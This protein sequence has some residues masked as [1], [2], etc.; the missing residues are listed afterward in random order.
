MW[1]RDRRPRSDPVVSPWIQ[2]LRRTPIFGHFPTIIGP[3]DNSKT[4]P[5]SYLC[6]SLFLACSSPLTMCGDQLFIQRFAADVRRAVFCSC[7][8]NHRFASPESH[9]WNFSNR[10]QT[11]IPQDPTR[12]SGEGCSVLAK[13]IQ[14]RSN[15]WTVPLV[16]QLTN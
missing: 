8:P 10:S 13:R 4:I 3:V 1:S 5:V 16:V 14:D 11:W 9:R 12:Y 15:L 2:P 7:A 6:F